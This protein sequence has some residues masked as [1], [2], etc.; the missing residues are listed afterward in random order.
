MSCD[1]YHEGGI[2]ENESKTDI[3]AHPMP[4]K[5]KNVAKFQVTN[6]DEEDG[7]IINSNNHYSNEQFYAEMKEH[8]VNLSSLG[9]STKSL[10]TESYMDNSYKFHN[11]DSTEYC[12]LLSPDVKN[13]TKRSNNVTS[14]VT[15]KISV[16]ED[17]AT[18]KECSVNEKIL[19][20]N[21]SLTPKLY[22]SLH[23]QT[24]SADTIN[25]IRSLT[26]SFECKSDM[27]KSTYSFDIQN[28][29]LPMTPIARNNKIKKN[30]WLSGK[31]DETT[32]IEIQKF[33]T[34]DDFKESCNVDCLNKTTTLLDIHLKNYSDIDTQTELH[35]PESNSYRSSV[36][37][38]TDIFLSSQR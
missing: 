18:D 8:S 4:A 34:N 30:A 5:M 9:M 16:S 12:T 11:T 26:N 35:I 27:N 32:N 14:N 24:P 1:E 2:T 10:G 21:T 36:S 28:T 25:S 33:P 3:N 7:C 22:K 15:P 37:L 6:L 20:L 17:A 13:L 23:I 31:S 38:N 19:K 29:S